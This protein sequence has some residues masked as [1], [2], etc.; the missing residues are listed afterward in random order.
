M[1][2]YNIKLG[3]VVTLILNEI[4]FPVSHFLN[5]PELV[6]RFST[7]DISTNT[8]YHLYFS[9]IYQGLT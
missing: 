7:A 2:L 3:C 1:T 8:Y 6:A 5:L 4:G 9:Q